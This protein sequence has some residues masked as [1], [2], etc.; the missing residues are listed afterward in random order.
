VS[1]K[2]QNCR[3]AQVVPT[4]SH[5]RVDI[6][7][8]DGVDSNMAHKRHLP[9]LTDQCSGEAEYSSFTCR[10]SRRSHSAFNT[11]QRGYV[12]DAGRRTTVADLA[13]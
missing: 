6:P 12:N 13:R 11:E 10:I 4:L 2:R 3:D 5:R 1:G 7:R 9:M 8:Y